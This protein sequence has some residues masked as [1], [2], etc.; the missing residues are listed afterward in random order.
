MRTG[1][2][3]YSICMTAHARASPLDRLIAFAADYVVI[4]VY[5]SLLTMTSFLVGM[6]EIAP[7]L[8][9][10]GRLMNHGFAF[11]SLTL[12]VILYFSV[13]ECG[14]PSASLGKR[15]RGLQVTGPDGGRPGF[16]RA[17]LRNAVKFTPWELAHAAIWYVPGRPFIDPM[18]PA[19]L[20]VCGLAIGLAL[21]WATSLLSASG[22]TPYDRLTGTRVVRRS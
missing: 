7:P 11:L 8:T 2:D 13:M 4:A 17:L 6:D 12:P 10:T 15:L 1:A 14:D 9:L 3:R 21:L 19:N 20:A 18:P 5:A 22:R 16:A